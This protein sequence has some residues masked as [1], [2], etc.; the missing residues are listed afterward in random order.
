MLFYHCLHLVHY[1]QPYLLVLYGS[2]VLA[3]WCGGCGGIKRCCCFVIGRCPFGEYL[4]LY[5]N[6]TDHSLSNV[7]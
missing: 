3:G 2:F 5:R 6:K 1:W 4:V 7:V